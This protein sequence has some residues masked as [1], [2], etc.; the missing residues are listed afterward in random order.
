MSQN[1]F[2]YFLGFYA[3]SIIIYQLGWSPLITAVFWITGQNV[4][5]RLLIETFLAV[6]VFY[7]TPYVL[8]KLFQKFFKI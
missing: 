2:K 1:K 6:G 7:I 3:L 5:L 4:I 8:F